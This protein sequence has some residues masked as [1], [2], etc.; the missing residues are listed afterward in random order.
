MVRQKLLLALSFDVMDDREERI[1]PA[2]DKTCDWLLAPGNTS[3]APVE[4][5][6]SWLSSES[7][8]MLWISGK[9][10][11]GK[12]TLM[13]FLAQAIADGKLKHAF[14]DN[15]TIVVK[16]FFYRAEDEQYKLQMSREGMMRSILHQCLKQEKTWIR[17]VFPE[18]F[19]ESLQHDLDAHLK[20]NVPN[21]MWLHRAFSNMFDIAQRLERKMLLLIDGLDEYRILHRIGDYTQKQLDLLFDS[22]NDDNAWGD[23]QWIYDGHVELVQ[24][25]EN[26]KSNNFVKICVSSRELDV[27]EARFRNTP[28]IRVQEHTATGIA[29]YCKTRLGN[30]ARDLDDVAYLVKAVNR[31][32]QGV[33]LWVRLVVGL[34]IRDNERGQDAKQIRRLINTLP[35]RLGGESG[36]YWRM[37]QHIPEE[38]KQQAARMLYIMAKSTFTVHPSQLYWAALS[39]STQGTPVKPPT[40]SEL[41]SLQMNVDLIL[42]EPVIHQEKMVSH[43]QRKLQSHCL[44]LLEVSRTNNNF[45]RWGCEGRG[46]QNQHQLSEITAHCTIF[47]HSTARAFMLRDSTQSRLRREAFST[48]LAMLDGAMLAF[49][50]NNLV[51]TQWLLTRYGHD[52]GPHLAQADEAGEHASAVCSA[53]ENLNR[54]VRAVIAALRSSAHTPNVVFRGIHGFWTCENEWKLKEDGDDTQDTENMPL[55]AHLG[56]HT[57]TMMQLRRCEGQQ[58]VELANFLL[59]ETLTPWEFRDIRCVYVPWKL[60]NALLQ[61]GAALSTEVTVPAVEIDEEDQG[62][63]GWT[64]VTAWVLLLG[65]L[66]ESRTRGCAFRESG[67]TPWVLDVDLELSRAGRWRG[68]SATVNVVAVLLHHG[69]HTDMEL[70]FRRLEPRSHRPHWAQMSRTGDQW[71]KGAHV[72]TISASDV[73]RRACE[74]EMASS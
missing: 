55:A 50:N 33:F 65:G 10:G 22:S 72:K 32:A 15:S 46:N 9:A 23:S 37:L 26:L 54:V 58:R 38:F 73:L 51:F 13:K 6:R 68:K 35:E 16:F 14:I 29:H 8:S 57:V 42:S 74:G 53:F 25:L 24:V 17:E 12:S 60:V 5:M 63:P 39:I 34:I 49:R 45:V 64:T 20:R 71:Y 11:S 2:F 66:A 56:L 67:C 43:M 59:A 52:I 70:Q 61:S 44:G 28:R 48:P 41:R 31:R 47:M 3:H 30:E 18:L 27:F 36:L 1:D 19:E 62:R 4:R 7:E 40:P 21:W 69:A